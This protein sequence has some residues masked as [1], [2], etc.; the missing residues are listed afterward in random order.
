MDTAPKAAVL[1]LALAL[2]RSS[3]ALPPAI[4]APEKTVGPETCARCHDKEVEVWKGTAHAATFEGTTPLHARPQAQEIARKLGVRL[5]K[6]DSLCLDCH[7]TPERRGE[8]TTARTGVSCESCHGAARDWVN[9]HNG[10][11]G[12]DV[13]RDKESSA[14]RRERVARNAALG[15]VFSG[16]LYDLVARCYRCHTVP[17]EKLVA[18]GGHPRGGE[19]GFLERV[20]LVR[21]N[22]LRGHR[23]ENAPFPPERRRQLVVLAPLAE[24]E[25]QLRGLAEASEPG[26]AYVQGKARRIEKLVRELGKLAAK[27]PLPELETALAA[28]EGL[29]LEAGNGR[30]LALAADRV[31][32]AGR[33]FFAAHDGSRLAALDALAGGDEEETEVAAGGGEVAALGALEEAGSTDGEAGATSPAGGASAGAGSTSTGGAG[34]ASSGGVAPRPRPQPAGKVSAQLRA[35]PTGRKVVGQGK[36]DGCHTEQNG[37]WYDDPHQHAADP[38]LARAVA[39]RRISIT[40]YGRPVDAELATGRAV[41]M[42]CHGTVVSGKEA[43]EVESGPSCESCH[44]PAGDFLKPHPEAPRATR[45]SLGMVDLADPAKRAEVCASCH[46]VTDPRLLASGHPSGK[47]FDLAARTTAIAH[48]KKAQPAG[49]A[50][51]G[52]YGAVVAR[53]GP[54]PQVEVVAAELPTG[55]SGPSSRDRAVAG[56]ADAGE[57]AYRRAATVAPAVP[58]ARPWASLAA[59]GRA[60]GPTAGAPALVDVELP[61]LPEGAA[62]LPLAELLRLLG[63]RLDQLHRAASGGA[64]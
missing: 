16:T 3:S 58:T 51:A 36:C 34:S 59:D 35:M 37:W 25:A 10:F 48:W 63:R 49:S 44:G 64:P 20:D 50:L 43:A 60:A 13:E 18:V 57:A 55:S 47:G 53:R 42:D 23:V 30:P 56:T 14:T 11:Q 29:R 52:A 5:I 33:G 38:F 41:C 19:M 31:A 26:S 28:A 61:P 9:V 1:A 15:M 27:A 2:A 54:L 8:R 22:F 62:S 21:H 32:A 46:Y 7:F 4:E 24:L 12:R 39:V 45:L 40:Y 17:A 6:H